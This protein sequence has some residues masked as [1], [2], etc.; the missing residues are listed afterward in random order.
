MTTPTPEAQPQSKPKQVNGVKKTS[1]NPSNDA[2]REAAQKDIAAGLVSLSSQTAMG[3][4]A[5]FQRDRDPCKQPFAILGCGPTTTIQ[6]S[7]TPGVLGDFSLTMGTGGMVGQF[8]SHLTGI[9]DNGIAATNE[10]LLAA[11]QK[12]IETEGSEVNI[13]IPVIEYGFT[14]SFD[15]AHI[16][17]SGANDAGAYQALDSQSQ[18][19][20][21]VTIEEFTPFVLRGKFSAALTR[22][23]AADYTQVSHR[24]ISGSFVVAAPWKG[25]RDIKINRSS[26]S[27]AAIQDLAEV[28]PILG[29]LD[30]SAPI[31][32]G[33]TGSDAAQSTP[34]V[35][36]A[37]GF[38]SCNC[39]CQPIESYD[40]VCRSIC[41]VKVQQCAAQETLQA[42][43]TESQNEQAELNQ[44]ANDVDRMRADYKAFMRDNNMAHMQ[45]TM[46]ATFDQQPTAE[47]KRF[48]LFTQGMPVDGYGKEIIRMP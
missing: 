10:A 38:P 25:D 43:L 45:D 21:H 13:V 3:S 24:S 29:T 12:M 19:T 8:L 17:V 42:A 20:G 31:R 41:E 11:Q 16:T 44:L 47:A 15:N 36:K 32:S 9:A 33:A 30:L 14:G 46:L 39:T 27:D 37:S 35:S 34:P 7:L 6:L 40:A 48:F 5:F 26:S 23:S 18:H 1:A 28:I 4:R 22:T 2:T